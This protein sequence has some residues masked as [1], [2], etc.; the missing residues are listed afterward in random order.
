MHLADR[1]LRR[2]SSAQTLRLARSDFAAPVRR[3]SS[4]TGTPPRDGIV[5]IVLFSDYDHHIQ[6]DAACTAA[7]PVVLPVPGSS[8][9]GM[10]IC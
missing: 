1:T 5:Q 3:H 9:I 10:N 7:E 2:Y 6:H 8:L 4:A